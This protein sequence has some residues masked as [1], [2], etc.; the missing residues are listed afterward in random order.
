MQLENSQAACQRLESE[1]RA[2][3]VQVREL[4]AERQKARVSDEERA[5]AEA[6]Q[7]AERGRYGSVDGIDFWD[8]VSV[9]V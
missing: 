5:R 7:E 9:L 6:K 3:D 4:Q 2:L 1:K 8:L